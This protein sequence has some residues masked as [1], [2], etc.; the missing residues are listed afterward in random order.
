[1]SNK[2]YWIAFY[3]ASLFGFEPLLLFCSLV[4]LG[5]KLNDPKVFKHFCFTICAAYLPDLYQHLPQCWWWYF[6]VWKSSLFFHL[7]FVIFASYL[8]HFFQPMCFCVPVRIFCDFKDFFLSVMC[9]FADSDFQALQ[10]TRARKSTSIC[11][12]RLLSNQQLPFSSLFIFNLFGTSLFFFVAHLTF[13]FACCLWNWNDIQVIFNWNAVEC[14]SRRI[15]FIAFTFFCFL[16]K[17]YYLLAVCR[18]YFRWIWPEM[19]VCISTFQQLL[20]FK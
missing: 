17:Q 5:Q 9:A 15:D 2:S 20:V 1:M 8:K 18:L 12:F 3:L 14:S 16:Q 10:E 6:I 19:F 7:V 13:A 4:W 11:S